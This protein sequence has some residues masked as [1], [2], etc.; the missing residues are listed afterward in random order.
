MN[1]D[2]QVRKKKKDLFF[3]FNRHGSRKI[4]MLT[5]T[6]F[7][8]YII[9]NFRASIYTLQLIFGFTEHPVSLIDK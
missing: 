6:C 8:L 1:I 5:C 2:I 9:W 7:F 4:G 3:F